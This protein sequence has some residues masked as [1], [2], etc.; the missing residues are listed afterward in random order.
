MRKR[1]PTSV[2]DGRQPFCSIDSIRS[3]HSRYN[4]AEVIDLMDNA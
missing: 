2:S 3:A 4:M 1:L